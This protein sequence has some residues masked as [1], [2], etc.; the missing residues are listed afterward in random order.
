MSLPAAIQAQLDQAAAIE[1]QVYGTPTPE[2]NPD[3]QPQ[4]VQ[5]A[6]QQPVVQPTQVSSTPDPVEEHRLKVL[7]GKYNAEV[8]RLHQQVRELSAKLDQAV[9]ALEAKAAPPEQDSKL[10]T[11]ADVEAYGQDLVDM[12]RRAAREEFHTL[13]KALKAELDAR[14][15]GVAEQVTRAE[16]RIVQSDSD[17]FWAAVTAPGAAPDFMQVNEDPRWFAFLDSR[18][19]GT[20][21]TRRALA[22][23]AI[24]RFDATALVEQAMAFKES[25]GVALEPVVVKPNKPKSDLSKQVTPDS[26]RATTPSSPTGKIWSGAEYAAAQDPRNLKH[27]SK[28]DYDRGVAEADQAYAEGRVRF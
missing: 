8:P 7:Q 16:Q 22:E 25:L 19:P 20:P 11:A 26:S 21:F 24:A 17:K 23:E 5:T 4:G 3:P 28:E 9:S 27:M 12:A 2:G 1:A 14:Y 10:I 15:G 18:A 6:Q 13:A